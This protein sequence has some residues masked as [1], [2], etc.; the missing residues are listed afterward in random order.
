MHGDGLPHLCLCARIVQVQHL[1]A[2]QPILHT[3]GARDAVRIERS[4]PLPASLAYIGGGRTAPHSKVIHSKA[5]TTAHPQA[6]CTPGS[7]TVA[8]FISSFVSPSL[9]SLR[10]A[11]GRLLGSTAGGGDQQKERQWVR[12]CS[13]HLFTDPGCSLDPPPHVGY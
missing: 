13:V 2:V 4:R 12:P 6:E 1:G 7:P 11:R 9:H 3:G 5:I 8:I 10:S